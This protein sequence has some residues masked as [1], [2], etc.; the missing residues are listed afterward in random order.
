MSGTLDALVKRSDVRGVLVGA[1]CAV[2]TVS[3]V[4]VVTPSVGIALLVLITIVAF[5][6]YPAMALRRANARA[7]RTEVSFLVG[8]LALVGLGIAAHP[9]WIGIALGLH[10]V[11]DLAHERRV[12]TL[13]TRT[14]R[15]YACFCFTYDCL[16]GLAIFFVLV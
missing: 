8:G 16:V 3:F 7:I 9:A 14:S 6:A 4:L 15:W 10:G 1:H 5:A 13:F 11:I 2:I 12:T